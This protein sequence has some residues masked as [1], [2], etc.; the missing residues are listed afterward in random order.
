MAAP[1]SVP[2][3]MGDNVTVTL[4]ED[5]KTATFT[6]DLSERFGESGSGKSLIIASTHGNLR[7]PGTDVTTSV[8]L[9]VKNPNY[10]KS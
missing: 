9:Y 2:S 8:N 1:K 3:V 10:K 5:G 6:V 7:I 4:S